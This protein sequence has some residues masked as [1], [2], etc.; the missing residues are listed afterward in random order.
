MSHP[1]RTW[2]TVINWAPG[3][4]HHS[5]DQPKKKGTNTIS[6]YRMKPNILNIAILLE[7]GVEVME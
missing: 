3:S 7:E 5:T 6:N 1:T 2:N 4:Q